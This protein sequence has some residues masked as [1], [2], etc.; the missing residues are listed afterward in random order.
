[1]GMMFLRL[2]L[3]VGAAGLVT[4]TGYLLLVVIASVR[5]RREERRWTDAALPPVTLLKPVRGMEPDLEANL[6]SF[7]EQQYPSF[8]IIFGARHA[9]DPAL[10]VVRRI[11]SKHPSV[12]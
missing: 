4:S 5:F 8:E 7:F 6:T 2:L 10:E 11:S 9:D 3:I 1:M 12:P